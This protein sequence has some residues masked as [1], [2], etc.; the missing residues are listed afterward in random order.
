M[1][2]LSDSQVRIQFIAF[3]IIFNST[4]TRTTLP[5]N[6]NTISD[7]T[8]YSEALQSMS[9]LCSTPVACYHIAML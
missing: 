7:N 5:S 2:S 8:K 4:Q 6:D 1:K 9:C 3:N